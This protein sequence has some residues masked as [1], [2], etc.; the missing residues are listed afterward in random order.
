MGPVGRGRGCRWRAGAQEKAYGSMIKG[1]GRPGRGAELNFG[2]HSPLE[3]LFSRRPLLLL[4]FPRNKT[5]LLRFAATKNGHP[6]I[7]SK[8]A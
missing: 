3:S 4:Y 2:I 6:G 8:P 5:A 7:S 1:I